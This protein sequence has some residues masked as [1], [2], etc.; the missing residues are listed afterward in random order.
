MDLPLDPNSNERT[1]QLVH[2]T[3]DKYKVKKNT[4][5]PHGYFS[6]QER[7]YLLIFSQNSLVQSP[8]EGTLTSLTFSNFTV[9]MVTVKLTVFLRN[10]DWSTC[11]FE[12]FSI[13]VLQCDWLSL[14]TL[15][16]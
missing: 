3:T 12:R 7:K 5:D 15:L 14:P 6:F 4:I 10:A 11:H 16:I 1:T 13:V 2:Y 8:K 9:T